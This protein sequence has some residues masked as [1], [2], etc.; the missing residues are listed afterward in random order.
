MSLLTFS[1]ARVHFSVVNRDS[2]FREPKRSRELDT[3]PEAA[4][5]NQLANYCLI[6]ALGTHAPENNDRTLI[7]QCISPPHFPFFL[8][9]L[10]SYIIW[11]SSRTAVD[12]C[13]FTIA[14]WEDRFEEDT[15]WRD[16][17]LVLCFF[18]KGFPPYIVV[19]GWMGG[20]GERDETLATNFEEGRERRGFFSLPETDS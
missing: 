18:R 12:G 20:V 19:R 8:F 5:F 14:S 9:P 11:S 15:E 13:V 17:G 6:S 7:P 16:G 2:H 3:N 4:Y 10:P 1:V